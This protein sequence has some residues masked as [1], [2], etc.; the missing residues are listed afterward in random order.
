MKQHWVWMLAC[1]G[2]AASAHATDSGWSGLDQEIHTLAAS[3]QAPNAATPKVGGY[4]ITALDYEANPPGV[5]GDLNGDGDTSDPGEGVG[6]EG[7]DTLGWS[8]RFVRA[9]VSGDLGHDYSYKISFELGSG[10]AS[11]RDAYASWKVTDNIKMRWGRYKV[12][13]VRSALISD[14]KLLFLQRTHIATQIGFRDL[15]AMVS[16]QFSK[17]N[18]VVNAQNGPDGATNELFYNAR[19]SFDAI[20]DGVGMV[21][22]AYGAGDA[23]GLV[24]GAAIGDY[25]GV[26]GG[27]RWIAD[28][29]FTSGPF[30][31]A[32]EIADFDQDVGD[33]TPWDASASFLFADVY[34]V[35]A[36]YEDYDTDDNTTSY[37]VALNRY[38]AGHDVKWQAQYQRIDTDREQ[39][40]VAFDRDIFSLG[41]V[42]AF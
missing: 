37:G 2:L 19:V 1:A 4:I 16:G 15:G 26:D 25:T 20:G 30:S 33:N 36:R 8:F 22:G 27:V 38:V 5:T 18:F 31:L 39:D 28:A 17:V 35:A 41:L 3:L 10:V 23:A 42:V 29:A 34:E 9:E 11:I 32:A 13:F 21:E 40:D 12:P 6:F 7:D 24:V 14:T